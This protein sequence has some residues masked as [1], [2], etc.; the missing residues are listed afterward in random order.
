MA[1]EAEKAFDLLEWP[2]LFKTL[3]AFNFPPEIILFIKIL[4][5]YR[6][7]KI[8]TNN[9]LCDEIALEMGTMSSLLLFAL[10]I[11]PYAD[12]IKHDPNVT[13]ISIGKHE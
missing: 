3:E 5:K 9:T 7:V 13:G 12:R 6:K 1:V 10:A 2:L 8:Q 4:Y 11:K